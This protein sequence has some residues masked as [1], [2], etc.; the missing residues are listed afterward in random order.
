[1]QNKRDEQMLKR[2]NLNVEPEGPLTETS[3]KQ[4]R[5]L[6]RFVWTGECAFKEYTAEALI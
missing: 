2:R 6:G 3:N 1:M 4:V 5:D